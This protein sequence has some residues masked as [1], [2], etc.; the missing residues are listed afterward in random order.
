MFRYKEKILTRKE[1]ASL[2]GLTHDEINLKGKI[3]GSK[4][5]QLARQIYHNLTI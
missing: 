1:K 4:E 5:D 3:I 2:A